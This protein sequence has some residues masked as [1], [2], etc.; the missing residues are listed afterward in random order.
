MKRLVLALGLLLALPRCLDFEGA[1]EDYC[2]NHPARCSPDGGAGAGGGAAG[3]A[4]GA[5][6]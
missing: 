1:A 4:G 2:A 5:G 6:G 3:G